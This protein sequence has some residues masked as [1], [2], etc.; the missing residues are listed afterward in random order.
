MDKNYI[1]SPDGKLQVK[2]EEITNSCMCVSL[3]ALLQ[4]LLLFDEDTIKHHTC[5]FLGYAVNEKIS[6]KLPGYHFDTKQTINKTFAPSRWLDKFSLRLSRNRRYPFLKNTK[7]YAQDLGFL[8][9][10]IGKQTYSMLADGP[11]F[12]TMNMQ[13]DS[14]EYQRH[15]RKRH[16]LQGKVEKLLYGNVAVNT[17]GNNPQ[18][19]AFYLTE[20]NTSPVLLN[21]Q[22]YVN[23]FQELWQESS[24]SKKRFILDLFDV[25]DEDTQM[26]KDKSIMFLTQPLV[27]DNMLTEQE[28]VSLLQSVFSGY[29]ASQIV[30][31]THPRDRFDYR[32][33]FPEIAVYDKKINIQLLLLSDVHIQRAVTICSSSINAFPNDVEA[34]WF[35]SQVHPAIQQ[36]YGDMTPFRPYNQKTI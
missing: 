15:E 7:I 28:Y 35:G 30:I 31:K 27:Q 6:A 5:Y 3:Y 20:E 18:C 14:A 25:N 9:S 8:S 32:R 29:D 22:A 21:K 12:L 34:D 26:L 2:Y 19:Q 11:N 23:S 4:Y 10:L 24:D 16:S 17:L 33:Y 36:Y 1:Q 13:P